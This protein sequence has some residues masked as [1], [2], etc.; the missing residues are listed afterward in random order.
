[1]VKVFVLMRDTTGECI[2]NLQV[3]TM[4]LYLWITPQEKKK[5]IAS[6]L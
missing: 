5:S 6:F 2:Y 1:M 3:I 4:K